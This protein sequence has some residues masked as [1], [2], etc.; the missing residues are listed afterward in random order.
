MCAF[1]LF[2]IQ[3]SGCFAAVLQGTVTTNSAGNLTRKSGSKRRYVMLNRKRPNKENT[4]P[5]KAKAAL[6]SV[7]SIQD[8]SAF[9]PSRERGGLENTGYK[10]R[11]C[12]S[13]CNEEWDHSALVRSR[14]SLVGYGAGSQSA[15]KVYVRECI[16]PERQLHIRDGLRALP[17]CWAFYRALMGVSFNLISATFGVGSVTM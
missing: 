9:R 15:R 13:K 6:V 1:C 11:C 5:K 14:A 2:I 3:L 17:V 7:E 16:S 12:N 8:G 4:P 10:C